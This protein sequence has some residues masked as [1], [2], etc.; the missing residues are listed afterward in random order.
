MSSSEPTSREAREAVLEGAKTAVLADR[1]RDYGDPEDNFNDL[2]KLWNSWL[3]IRK[4]P[5]SPINRTDTAVMMILV[6]LARLTTSPT[7]EDHWTDIAGY[8]ACGYASALA[9]ASQEEGQS[10]TVNLSG[11]LLGIE[12][13]LKIHHENMARIRGRGA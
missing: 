4:P 11:Y 2:A 13:S 3:D 10:S 8:A 12:D 5:G 1:N 9:D 7:V 6:K